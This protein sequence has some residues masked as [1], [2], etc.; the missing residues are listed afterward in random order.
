MALKYSCASAGADSC[1]F[2]TTAT[3]KADLARQLADH[4][5]RVHAVTTPTQTILRYL[6]K[7]AEDRGSLANA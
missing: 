1:G 3:D 4:L 2:S 5:S 6:V 7:C